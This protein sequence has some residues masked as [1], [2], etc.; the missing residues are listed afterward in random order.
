MRGDSCEEN[1]SQC[2]VQVLLYVVFRTC[3][4][5]NPSIVAARLATTILH[6]RKPTFSFSQ[7]LHQRARE[8]AKDSLKVCIDGES[9]TF[10]KAMEI[11]RMKMNQ[12]VMD[13]NK[14]AFEKVEKE[15]SHP[16]CLVVLDC[17]PGYVHVLQYR[18]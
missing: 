14:T 9:D 1:F 10:S 16:K 4:N 2:A 7:G 8:A 11:D 6:V 3:S 5:G 17:Y 13:L 18:P 12:C 15:V